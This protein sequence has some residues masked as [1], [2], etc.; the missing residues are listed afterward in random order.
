MHAL[1][2]LQEAAGGAKPAVLSVRVLLPSEMHLPLNKQPAR[3]L[4]VSRVFR[5]RDLQDEG[6]FSGNNNHIFPNNKNNR[7]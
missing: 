6:H 4:E 7:T 2:D 3:N 5:V 1:Q